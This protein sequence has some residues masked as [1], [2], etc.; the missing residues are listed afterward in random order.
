MTTGEDW[1]VESF[2]DDEVSFPEPGK[3]TLR[4]ED[5]RRTSGRWGPVFE[6]WWTFVDQPAPRFNILT[7]QTWRKSDALN[8][9]RAFHG[10]ERPQL[11]FDPRELIGK[12]LLA[13]TVRKANGF[14]GIAAVA[15]IDESFTYVIQVK[16]GGAA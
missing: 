4:L 5:I 12:A 9:A 14:P 1:I 16:K 6:W 15:S 2:G 11:P 8:L 7:P 3:Y 10:G 13:R